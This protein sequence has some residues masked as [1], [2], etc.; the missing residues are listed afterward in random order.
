VSE[1]LK[2]EDVTWHAVIGHN[3]V[4][5]FWVSVGRFPALDM[6]G[7]IMINSDAVQTKDR[8]GLNEII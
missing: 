7:K 5:D 2:H 8:K 3:V 1:N 4:V 6:Y